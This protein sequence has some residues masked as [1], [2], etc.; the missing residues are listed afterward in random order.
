MI[1]AITYGNHKFTN[2]KKRLVGQLEQYGLFDYIKSYGPE[3]LDPEFV[4]RFKHI[5]SQPRIGGYGIW[6]PYI[7]K[8]ELERLKDGDFLMYID[9]GCTMVLSGKPRFLEYIEMLKGSDKGIISFSMDH[10]L[11]KWYTTKEIFQYFGVQD[12]KEVTDS[13]QYLSGILIIKKCTHSIDLIDTWMKAV[14]DQAEMFTDCYNS[15]QEEYFRDNRHEQSVLSV[16]R[17]IKGSIVIPDET[18][19]EPFGTPKSLKYP[20]WATRIRG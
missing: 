17:K 5:L 1:S 6:R 10:L 2:S 11:E 18:W 19:F 7:I 3:D 8:K 4:E 16:L 15:K 13:G 20:I 14:Y 12:D 9:A